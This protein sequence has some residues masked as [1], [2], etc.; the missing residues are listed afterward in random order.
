[1]HQ[2]G[3]CH[4]FSKAN[5]E[6]KMVETKTVVT[7]QDDVVSF[8]EVKDTVCEIL[9][10]KNLRKD[11][12]GW[13]FWWEVWVQ[14]ADEYIVSCQ[15]SESCVSIDG[16]LERFADNAKAV[17]VLEAFKQVLGEELSDCGVYFEYD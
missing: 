17:Q 8:T 6:K 1:L 15:V 12:L 14:H 2:A 13:D 11:G 10:V 5:I 16:L 3:A 9:G 7:V 4:P